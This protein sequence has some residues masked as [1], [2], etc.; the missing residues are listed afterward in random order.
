[1]SKLYRYIIE[2]ANSHADNGDEAGAEAIMFA[3]RKGAKQ[4]REVFPEHV[5]AINNAVEYGRQ[6]YKAE[7]A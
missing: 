6:Q 4:A 3:L 7:A 5:A 1:M 2:C